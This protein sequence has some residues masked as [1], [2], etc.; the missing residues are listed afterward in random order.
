MRVWFMRMRYQRI[1]LSLWHAKVFVSLSTF[2]FIFENILFARRWVFCDQLGACLLYMQD[3]F[4]RRKLLNRCGNQ[5]RAIPPFFAPSLPL[6]M[7]PVP[8]VATF[9]ASYI[10]YEFGFLVLVLKFLLWNLDIIVDWFCCLWA[11]TVVC[12]FVM[13]E[14]LRNLCTK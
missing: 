10:R 2:A 4:W 1:D 13:I 9:D 3:V 6:K 5:S 12:V 14:L 7:S 8:N 11:D